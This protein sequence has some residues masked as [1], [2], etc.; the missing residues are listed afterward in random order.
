MSEIVHG[1]DLAAIGRRYGIDP[2]ELLDFSANLNPLGP[3]PS[4]L[5]ELAAASADVAELQR[6]PDPAARRLREA[7]AR[8][9]DIEPDSI[10]VGNGAAALLGTALAALEIRHCVVPTPA[11]SEDRHAVTTAGARWTGVPLDAARAFALEPACVVAALRAGAADACLITNPH[12]PSGALAG[13]D[14]VLQLARDAHAARAATIV[15]EAFVDYASEASVTRAAAVS[16]YRLVTIRSLTKFFAVPALRVGYAVAAPAL[17]RR[18]R[19]AL[20]SWP[21]TTLA[22]RA[23]AA[24]LADTDYVRRTLAENVRARSRLAVD[25]T[26]LGFAPNPSAAN[27]L[28]VA[29]PPEA[30]RARELV[31]RLVLDARIVMRD[32]SSYEGLDAGDYVRVAVRTTAENARLLAALASSRTWW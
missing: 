1:G 14:V 30:P 29:L 11:F 9:L 32:C 7:L 23:L 19:A 17:A 25:L 22:A 6:Y 26:A 28:L 24:A 5:R 10:V 16:E 31:Q 20:P 3:P 27:F 15:D 8:H 4:L 2:A 21:V 18:I 13:R 12:N